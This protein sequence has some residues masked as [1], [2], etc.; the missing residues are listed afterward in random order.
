MLFFLSLVDTI[1]NVTIFYN[2][3]NVVSTYWHFTIQLYKITLLHVVLNR[4]PQG[5]AF[6]C[7]VMERPSS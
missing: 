1:L 2:L 7:F 6:T 4:Y 5:I 3:S